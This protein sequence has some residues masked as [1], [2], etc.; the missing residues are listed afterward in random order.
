M[1]AVPRGM[2]ARRREELS[3]SAMPGSWASGLWKRAKVWG[4]WGMAVRPQ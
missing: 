4:A 1:G 2:E 3:G